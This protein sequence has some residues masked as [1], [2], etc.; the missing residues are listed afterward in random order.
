[1]KTNQK[2]LSRFVTA[3]FIITFI[4][5]ALTMFF[6]IRQGEITSRDNDDFKTVQT[7]EFAGPA[8]VVALYYD[9]ESDQVY[10]GYDFSTY[11]NVYNSDSEFLWA[12]STPYYRGDIFFEF[13]A[14]KNELRVFQTPDFESDFTVYTYDLRNGAFISVS[15]AKYSDYSEREDQFASGRHDCEF[16]YSGGT[17]YS[18]FFNVYM[19]DSAGSVK[20]IVK[21]PFWWRIAYN[22][23]LYLVPWIFM[24]ASAV[25][26]GF[27]RYTQPDSAKDE[28]PQT[29]RPSLAAVSTLSFMLR[30]CIITSAAHGALIALGL[31]TAAFIG[32]YTVFL[33]IPVFLHFAISQAIL[34]NKCEKY[35][36]QVSAADQRKLK[37]F[38]AVAFFSLLAFI[39]AYAVGVTSIYEAAHGGV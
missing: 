31:L 30:Y 8:N 27:Q 26:L 11:V 17:L 21:R 24:A 15:T 22:G 33:I 34:K 20:K 25:G 3:G 5:F 35:F 12:L 36:P 37:V 6:S 39:I 23:L 1:M 29:V 13:D 16:V 18:D 4:G 9:E 32:K 38:E 19:A 2:V 28:Q 10:V 7:E 14:D